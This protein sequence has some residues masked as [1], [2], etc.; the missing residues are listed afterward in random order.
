[1][2]KQ[3]DLVFVRHDALSEEIQEENPKSK[4]VESSLVIKKV[5]PSNTEIQAQ[6]WF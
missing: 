4:K 1:M 5:E 6:Q 2:K 3:K